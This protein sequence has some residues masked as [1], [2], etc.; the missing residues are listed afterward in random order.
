[1]LSRTPDTAASAPG[2]LRRF[3]R[4]TGTRVLALQA[5]ALVLAFGVAGALASVSIRQISE[6]A[7]Q[8]DVMGEVAS[9]NDEWLHKGVGHLPFTV[10]KRSRLWHGFEYGLTGPGGVY[11]AGNPGLA[12]LHRAGWA[13]PMAG[14]RRVLAYTELLPG[15]GQLTVGRDLT[16]EQHQ[17]RDLT[18][19]LALCGAAGVAICLA[20]A[21]LTTRWTWRRL[22]ELSSSAALVT[23]GRL[24]VRA[25]VKNPAA[26]D[27]I[28]EVSLAFN[29]M[30]DRISRLVGELRRVTMDVAHD[31]RRPLTRLRQKLERL[32]REAQSAPKIAAQVQRLDAEFLEIL[33]TFDALLQ[34]AE[35]EGSARPEDL[36]NLTDVTERVTEALRPDIEDG[37]RTLEAVMEP[38]M[39]RGDSDL[40][41]QAVVNLLENAARHTPAGTQIVVRVEANSGAPS[42]Q[43]RDN[44]PGIPDG[45]KNLAL[46]PWGRLEASRS[47]SGSGLGLAIVAS[48]AE[49]HGAQLELSDAQPGLDARLLFPDATAH[50]A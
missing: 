17:M 41:A 12:A 46:A 26:P 29:A 35:I 22:D 8:A 34:L 43:V 6:R 3:W 11:L 23:A 39:V 14:A 27:E 16:A 2:G 10:T 42:L 36:V 32:G 18:A 38:A 24:D 7:Y 30:L 19:L 9:L 21:Y 31:M 20:T 49:R 45:L 28:D 47:A 33:R 40:V 1:M 37:G 25:P 44:G 13:Q 4:R 48:I 5:L 15:G 50:S